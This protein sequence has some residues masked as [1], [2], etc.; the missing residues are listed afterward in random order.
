MSNT[1]KL[2]WLLA[3]SYKYADLANTYTHAHICV[4]KNKQFYV[5]CF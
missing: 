3:L 1:Y 5:F 4:S 2:L